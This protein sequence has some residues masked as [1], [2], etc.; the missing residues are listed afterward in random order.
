MLPPMRHAIVRAAFLG[1]GAVVTRHGAVYGASAIASPC[2]S[3]SLCMGRINARKAA[4]L[5]MWSDFKIPPTLCITPGRAHVAGL[6]LLSIQPLS[7]RSASTA[8]VTATS[9]AQ[10]GTEA[11]V[12]PTAESGDD[13]GRIETVEQEDE[14]PRGSERAIGW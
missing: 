4:S 8:T 7:R 3:R 9:A 11:P 5:L 10:A 6:A 2:L 13:L 12:S 14:P 1:G